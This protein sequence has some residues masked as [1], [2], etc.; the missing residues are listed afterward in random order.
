[1]YRAEYAVRNM[2]MLRKFKT[3]HAR[4]LRGRIFEFLIQYPV[5]LR[6][7][8]FYRHSGSAGGFVQENESQTRNF[9][10]TQPCLSQ[11]GAVKSCAL[12]VTNLNHEILQVKNRY[13]HAACARCVF[14]FVLARSCAF[15]GVLHNLLHSLLPFENVYV[16]F[17]PPTQVSLILVCF[18]VSYH[19]KAFLS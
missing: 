3:M 18:C 14:A 9:L 16:S 2:L 1:M 17:A 15:F 11:R 6:S 7:Y 5:L 13:E 12:L 10:D 8:S 4:Y 19:I